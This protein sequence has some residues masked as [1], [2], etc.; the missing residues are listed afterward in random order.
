MK[1][2]FLLIFLSINAHA[3]KSNLNDVVNKIKSDK[4]YTILST[5]C[6][7][8]FF[9]ESG[10]LYKNHIDYCSTNLNSCLKLCNDGDANYCLSLANYTQG[11]TEG[12]YYSEA[13][14][15][16]SCKLGQVSACTNRASGLIKYNGDSSLTCA[17][18]TFEL[19]CSK[20]DAWGCT[21]YGAYLAQGKGVERDFDKA[22][23]VLEVGCQNGIQD[24][25]CQNAQNI[26]N[27]IKAVLSKSE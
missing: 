17:V 8:E 7:T 23:K 22:L 9:P 13:L 20:N 2:V 21:M 1:F 27:Q 24:P 19:S 3:E 6:P 18:K 25:A 10:V 4:S 16:K 5:Q 26:S 12:E 15:S 14:F 11:K